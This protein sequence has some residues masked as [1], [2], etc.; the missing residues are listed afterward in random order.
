MHG[1]PHTSCSF[2]ALPVTNVT[3][4]RAAI[5]STL[6]FLAG[7]GSPLLINGRE[8]L[9]KA[10]ACAAS[11]TH[12]PSHPVPSDLQ[13][14]ASDTGRLGTVTVHDAERAGSGEEQSTRS[15]HRQHPVC[16]HEHES[17]D[18]SPAGPGERYVA[19]VRALRSRLNERDLN[20][21]C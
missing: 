12:S 10:P 14:G 5:W 8:L 4:L 18:A 6:S 2:F 19:D 11:P 3:A 7:D 20:E 9:L 16:R 1:P 17:S 21:R 13:M 15:T